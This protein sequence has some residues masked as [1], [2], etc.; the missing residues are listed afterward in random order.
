M[1]FE[2]DKSGVFKVYFENDFK[3]EAGQIYREVD[4]EWVFVPTDKFFYHPELTEIVN[5]IKELNLA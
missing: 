4:K 2:Y 1:I 3:V 5:K